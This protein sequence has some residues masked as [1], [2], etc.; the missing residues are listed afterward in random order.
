[1]CKNCHEEITKKRPIH[2]K[3]LINQFRLKLKDPFIQGCLVELFTELSTDD[4]S[5]IVFMLWELNRHGT[6][7]NE[8]ITEL[9]QFINADMVAKYNDILNKKGDL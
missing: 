7:I 9:Y 1:M 6:D 8:K 4:L 2:E 5:D 3:E